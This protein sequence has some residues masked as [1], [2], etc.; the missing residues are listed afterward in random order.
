M[1][2]T[3]T[4]DLI[5]L[6]G[7][8]LL[9]PVSL[10][11]PSDNRWLSCA[12][13]TGAHLLSG[14]LFSNDLD[15]AGVELRRW[16]PLRWI[17]WPYGRLIPHRSWLS[18]GLVVGPLLRLV[19]FALFVEVVAVV[20]CLGAQAVGRGVLD[21]LPW[22]HQFWGHLAVA[23]PRRFIEFAAGFILAGVSHSIPDWVET[24]IRRVI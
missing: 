24:G 8:A 18:H 15:V 23:Y 12:V 22:W 10:F 13:A 17:W 14:L 7:A 1:P 20:V 19:Y 21:G 5:T 2:P 16:G 6:G 9:V 11:V 3:R 4:H